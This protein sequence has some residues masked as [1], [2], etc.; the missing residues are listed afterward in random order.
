[1]KV[2]FLVVTLFS[3]LVS[4]EAAHI[5]TSIDPTWQF[6][7]ALDN[8][9][10]WHTPTL[11]GTHCSLNLTS[12]DN[13]TSSDNPNNAQYKAWSIKLEK[14]SFVRIVGLVSDGLAED[15][16]L[17]VYKHTFDPTKP[18]DNLELF[19]STLEQE[20]G[21][22]LEIIGDLDIATYWFVFSLDLDDSAEYG[23]QY[24]SLNIWNT[25]LSGSIDNS[26][27]SWIIP[28]TF[29]SSLIVNNATCTVAPESTASAHF[30]MT[31][32][33][34]SL[35][36]DYDLFDILVYLANNNTW[37]VLDQP[38]VALYKGDLIGS[39]LLDSNHTL[40]PCDTFE[41][42]T[43]INI[44]E[45]NKNDVTTRLTAAL[46]PGQVYTVVVPGTSP[47]DL[48]KVGVFVV[49]SVVETIK[50]VANSSYTFPVFF[51]STNCSSTNVTTSSWDIK[52]LVAEE[53]TY[54]INAW[55]KSFI[56]FVAVY[57][58]DLDL[59]SNQNASSNSSSSFNPCQN[60]IA[61]S[62]STNE[63]EP[64]V[65]KNLVIG[66][67]YTILV[68]SMNFNGALDNTNTTN[69][70]LFILGGTSTGTPIGSSDL[71]QPTHQALE[72]V[73]HVTSSGSQLAIC[74][75]MIAGALFA[76]VF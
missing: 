57:S 73:N 8:S 27:Q 15:G 3:L 50:N 7:S 25:S 76:I 11:N 23:V 38:I 32:F 75:A 22:N 18:C 45:G 49:P 13:S 40:Q 9:T 31:T 62:S 19:F 61:A 48:G 58:G 4:L 64:L 53:S 54:L 35:D 66:Q 37:S 17:F 70:Y 65:L 14:E 30:F 34:L 6:A 29:N 71:T 16:K 67:N 10:L 51:S 69:F 47:D 68:S 55:S 12:S 24:I 42:F 74:L 21:L 41:N 60:L 2:F 72:T 56:P 28:E 44:I 52:Y 20:N 39:G 36:E 5:I 33:S 46:A 1:M 63:S 43:L 59:A 26:S